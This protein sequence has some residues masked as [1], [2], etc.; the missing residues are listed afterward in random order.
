MALIS[1]RIHDCGW[2]EEDTKNS[3][4]LGGSGH[5]HEDC[6]TACMN[7]N[8]C[9]FAAMTQK[10]ICHLYQTCDG[11]GGITYSVYEKL[12]TGKNSYNFSFLALW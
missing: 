5:A 3:K 9:F 12:C 10:G 11:K 1:K 7:S 8:Y 6:L 2:N 4:T